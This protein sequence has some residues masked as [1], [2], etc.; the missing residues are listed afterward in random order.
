MV[1]VLVAF[2]WKADITEVG[3][4]FAASAVIL[5]CQELLQIQFKI[6]I[7]HDPHTNIECF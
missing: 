2:V 5:K 4:L 1:K 7:K 6:T 3:N